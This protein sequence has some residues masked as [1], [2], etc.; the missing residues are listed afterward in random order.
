MSLRIGEFGFPGPLRDRLVGAVLTGAKT[1]TSSLLA[2][3][4]RDGEALPSV[5]ERQVVVDS[6]GAQV[7]VIEIVAVEVLRLGAVDDR[8]ARAEGEEY[9]T[10]VDW[11]AEHERFWTEEVVPGWRDPPVLDE[12]TQVVVEWFCVRH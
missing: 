11:R 9:S 6:D 7:A 4:R 12:D 5:G 10:A 3:W 1:G 2:D 8:I